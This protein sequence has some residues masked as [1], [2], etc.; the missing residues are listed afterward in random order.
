MR[1]DPRTAHRLR[2]AASVLLLAACLW[3]VDVGEVVAAV[4]GLDPS[5]FAVAFVLNGI[6]TVAVRAWLAHLAAGRIE[7]R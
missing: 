5:M 7:V 3:I 2:I 4:R 1:L 6:G